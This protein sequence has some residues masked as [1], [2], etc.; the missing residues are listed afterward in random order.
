LAAS[1][2][3]GVR[4]SKAGGEPSEAIHDLEEWH[5]AL[6]AYRDERQRETKVRPT[7]GSVP[8]RR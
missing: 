3:P 6:D 7:P 4:P 2:R 5:D 1:P 8:E